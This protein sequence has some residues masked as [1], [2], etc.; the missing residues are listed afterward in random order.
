MVFVFALLVLFFYIGSGLYSFINFFVELFLQGG[1]LD[2]C[3]VKLLTC[4]GLSV[5]NFVKNPSKVLLN[6]ESLSL[7]TSGH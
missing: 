7:K 5:L 6:E 1:K 3:F 2:C 4:G